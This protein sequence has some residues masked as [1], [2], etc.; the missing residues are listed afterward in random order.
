MNFDIFIILKFAEAKKGKNMGDVISGAE[1]IKIGKPSAFH[2]DVDKDHRVGKFLRSRMNVIDLLPC[3][4]KLNFAA[5]METSE[6]AAGLLPEIEYD[7][8]EDFKKTGVTYGLNPV[9]GIRLYTTDSTTATDS[10]SNTLKDNY[11]QNG[12]NDL[13]KAMSPVKDFMKSID[14]SGTSSLIEPL[15]SR[16]KIDAGMSEND[17][18]NQ[19]IAS[20]VLNTGVNVIGKGHRISLPSIWSDSTYTP[21]FHARIKLVSPYGHPKAIKE[22]IIR[23]LMH[24]LILASPKTEDGVSYGDPYCLTIKAYGMNYTPIGMISNMTLHR[25]GNDTSYNLFRQPL[26]VDVD[27]DFQY[28]INGFAHYKHDK[29]TA[30]P[31]IFGSTDQFEFLTKAEN[32]SLP[33]VGH[34]I[35]SLTPREPEIDYTSYRANM[36]ACRNTKETASEDSFYTS[37]FGTIPTSS[38]SPLASVSVAASQA[39]SDKSLISETGASIAEAIITE[40]VNSVL[41]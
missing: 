27:L 29:N 31:D 20:A 24:L 17:I 3:S 23:P 41:S 11:F 10:I 30:E 22:F 39:M 40:A 25:G 8:M 2:N 18:Y 4:Y 7:A 32:A 1:L 9:S 14:S 36:D 28:L 6:D 12:L 16:P 13:S 38:G 37:L 26:S 19:K 5:G 33:T 15:L 35:K 21:N 34:L